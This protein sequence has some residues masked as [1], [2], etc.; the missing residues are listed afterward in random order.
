MGMGD[1]YLFTNQL[2]EICEKVRIRIYFCGW[3]VDLVWFTKDRDYDDFYHF[4]M[5][6]LLKNGRMYVGRKNN[7]KERVKVMERVLFCF[8]LPSHP[9]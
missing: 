7:I 9:L 8:L 6:R 4:S 3:N 2:R 1:C 5:R